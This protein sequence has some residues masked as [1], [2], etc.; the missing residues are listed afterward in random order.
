ETM[1]PATDNRFS[2]TASAVLSDYV[3]WPRI[4]ELSA[5]PPSNG[6]MEK[7][8]GA[9]MAYDR[10]DLEK[11]MQA[12]FNE[13]LDWDEYKA[14]GYGL[15]QKQAG[16]DPKAA[17]K[18]VIASEKFDLNRIVRYALRPFDSRWA[19]YTSV[20]P[21]WNRPRPT[22]WAQCWK[23]NRFLLTRF[24]AAKDPEGPPFYC[25]TNLSDDHFLSPDAVA[26]PFYTRPSLQRGSTNILNQILVFEESAQY[27]AGPTANLSQGA[28][29]YLVDLK[30]PNP[31]RDNASAELIWMH[32]LAIGYSPLY[33]KENAD[34]VRQDWPRI[35]L[36]NSRKL[37]LASVELGKSVAALLDTE[38]NVGGVTSGT[39]RS[40]L[41]SLAIVSRVGGGRLNPD[42]G[43]LAVT[44]G[45]GHGGKDG[46]TMPGKG[47]L[48]QRGYTKEE[49]QLIDQGI[50]GLRVS[51]K[52]AYTRL[53]ETTYDVYLNDRAYWKNIPVNVWEYTIGGYQVIKKWL[54]YRE[55]ELL[56]RP[57]T[58]DEA[59]EVMNMARRIPAIL[60]LEPKLDENYMAVKNATYVWPTN[61]S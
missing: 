31:D 2:F 32:A 46:V 54:S 1:E 22:L 57:L 28:R 10:D 20:N 19:Y 55:R 61:E 59:R 56:K 45:W 37:L 34:G 17:R 26:V 9:L 52:E 7:R 39:I 60:L 53:G 23:G 4:V 15:T 3:R 41:K 58:N 6:L 30:L 13:K 48:V 12:Y 5:I 29:A 16:F 18:K 47:K 49:E 51:K 43:D 21:V 42:A 38:S 11:R 27:Q 50:K 35:P 8:G 33:L 25:T 44:V 14:L 36:P 40:E 24:R